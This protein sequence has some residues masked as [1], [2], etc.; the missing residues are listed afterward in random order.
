MKKV[1]GRIDKDGDGKMNFKAEFCEGWILMKIWPRFLERYKI[2]RLSRAIHQYHMVRHTIAECC[3]CRV[4]CHVFIHF[5]QHLKLQVLRFQKTA[6]V[7]FCE[8]FSLKLPAR[9]S[10]KSWMDKDFAFG[11]MQLPCEICT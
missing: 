6:S 7:V 8:E 3:T 1:L 4:A 11:S 9:S 5:T 2:L 10:A